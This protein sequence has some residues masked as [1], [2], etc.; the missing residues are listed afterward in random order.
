MEGGEGRWKW[1]QTSRTQLII[2]HLSSSVWTAAV[3]LEQQHKRHYVLISLPLPLS[4]F[5]FFFLS[6]FISFCL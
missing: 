3:V 1:W 2:L 6:H 4:S 5:P